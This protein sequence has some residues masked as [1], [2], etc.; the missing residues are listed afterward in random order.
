MA[1][2]DDIEYVDLYDIVDLEKLFDGTS[3]EMD[4]RLLQRFDLAVDRLGLDKDRAIYF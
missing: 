3:Q 1:N 4:L 2:I